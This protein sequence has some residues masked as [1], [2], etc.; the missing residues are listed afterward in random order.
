MNLL[1]DLVNRGW[2]VEIWRTDDRA[3]PRG[4]PADPEFPMVYVLAIW[5]FD[6]SGTRV[7][8]GRGRCG[9]LDDAVA[10]ACDNAHKLAKAAELDAV[11]AEIEEACA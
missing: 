4:A 9:L 8:T 2:H 6:A 5:R 10:E 3:G 1:L 7:V 11:A